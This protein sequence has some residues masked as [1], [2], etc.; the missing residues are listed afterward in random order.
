MDTWPR[1]WQS[2]GASEPGAPAQI[3]LIVLFAAFC[4]VMAYVGVCLL[5][6]HQPVT[7]GK[8]GEMPLTDLRVG[9]EYAFLVPGR[10][11]LPSATG[12]SGIV[13]CEE[14]A[15]MAW[16]GSWRPAL[17][18]TAS[19][20]RQ[21]PQRAHPTNHPARHGDDLSQLRDG[22]HCGGSGT[23][24]QGRWTEA[25]LIYDFGARYHVLPLLGLS[26]A[27]AAILA[28][29]PLVRRCDTRSGRPA[30]MGAIVCLLMLLLHH[31]E[32][33]DRW[34]TMLELPDQKTTMAA[35]QHT[36]Q[37]AQEA[38]ISRSQLLRI[39]APALR[40]WNLG[41]LV[42]NSPGFPLMKLV[43]APE[44]VRQPLTDDQARA[45]LLE[46]L[47]EADRIAL[48]TGACASMTLGRPDDGAQT[49]AV[50]TPVKL[51]GVCEF[52]PGEFRSLGERA[53]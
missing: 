15:G 43:Q 34:A 21:R 5:G 44:H 23:V 8:R 40:A 6:G 29:C 35:L 50:A 10:L 1:L 17:V 16:L 22:I 46:R 25:Q 12:F 24:R 38:G 45:I 47:G 33:D 30:L 20:R 41:L 48:G 2:S 31:H 9:L 53:E 11:L 7:P 14:H 36:G 32:V 27:F 4:G 13:V 28:R 42:D 52:K 19:N 3:K 37:L 26:A 49:L 51:E 39:V 18:R